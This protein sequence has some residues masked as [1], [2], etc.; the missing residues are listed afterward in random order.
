MSITF[1]VVVV[2]IVALV[3]LRR[4]NILKQSSMKKSSVSSLQMKSSRPIV[5]YHTGD[6]MHY[7]MNLSAKKAYDERNDDSPKDSPDVSFDD[8]GD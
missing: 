5:S 6:P 1:F 4:A 3:I 7:R 8:A 2:I